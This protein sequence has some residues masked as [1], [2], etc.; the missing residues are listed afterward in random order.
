MK[1]IDRKEK[2]N[3]YVGLSGQNIVYSFIG[4]T[5]FTYFMTD[6]AMFPAAIVSVLLIVMKVWDGIN[7]PLVGSYVD[8][9]RFKNGEKLAIG[10]YDLKELKKFEV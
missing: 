9:H 4:G 2:L 3:F 1:Y 8:K 10:N 7:D 5:F 6:I